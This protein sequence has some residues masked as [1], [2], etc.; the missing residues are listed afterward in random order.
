MSKLGFVTGILQGILI[1]TVAVLLVKTNNLEKQLEAKQPVTDLLQM[2]V[3]NNKFEKKI[4]QLDKSQNFM[5]MT[6]MGRDE[7][8]MQEWIRLEKSGK[9][10]K[11]FSWE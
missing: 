7:D 8:G 5:L 3:L 1:I 11:L 2:K 6:N 9:I 10:D 4:R